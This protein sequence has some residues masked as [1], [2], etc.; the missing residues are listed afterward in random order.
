MNIKRCH[1]FKT[2]AACCYIFITL[3]FTN[4][5]L[6]GPFPQWPLADEIWEM[7]LNR[8]D[9]AHILN[10]REFSG[11]TGIHVLQLTEDSIVLTIVFKKLPV[12][13]KRRQIYVLGQFCTI[14]SKT[15][16]SDAVFLSSA[17]TPE[18]FQK[19]NLYYV[20]RNDESVDY[21]KCTP[22]GSRIGM[23]KKKP[24]SRS[25]YRFQTSPTRIIMHAALWSKFFVD[26]QN[27]PKR[28]LDFAFFALKHITPLIK[29]ELKKTDVTYLQGRVWFAD[30][31]SSIKLLSGGYPLKA[32]QTDEL[33][34]YLDTIIKAR[35]KD[36]DF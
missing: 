22:P 3:S 6:A 18:E 30:Q 28:A 33:I 34:T 5:A 2:L 14:E 36:S 23:I 9:P 26:Y 27:N 19:R 35:K 11:E 10:F 7:A 12:S 8:R 4:N 31:Y 24:G 1:N 25:K 32:S 15:W 17:E 13:D 29:T 21:Q 16:I 20:M